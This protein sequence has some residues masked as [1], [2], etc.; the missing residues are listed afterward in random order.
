MGLV[1][2]GAGVGLL[3]P[4]LSNTATACATG[5]SRGQALGL[6]NTGVFLGQFISPLAT[7]PVLDV[8]GVGGAYGVAGGV[9]L[10]IAALCVVAIGVRTTVAVGAK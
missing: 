2:A 5:A 7:Q 3:F 8:T 10:A 9:C 4:H 6:L 1:I